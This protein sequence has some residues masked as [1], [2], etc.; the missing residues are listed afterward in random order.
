LALKKWIWKETAETVGVLGVIATLIFVAFEVRQN[1]QVSRAASIQAMADASIQIALAWAN[2]DEGL[3]LLNQVFN[4]AVPS[5]LTPMENAKLRMYYVAALRS[6]ESRYRQIE[7][8]L[9]P[10]G[11]AWVG[12]SAAIYSAQYAAAYWPVLR[13][14]IA[15]DFAAYMEGEYGLD[16]VE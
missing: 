16:G 15:A 2:D 7:L 14:T 11:D 6:A 1:T 5:D 12:G 3:A 4:G 9:L 10:E 13:S 8:G